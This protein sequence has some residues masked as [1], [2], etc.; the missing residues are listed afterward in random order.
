MKLMQT[1]NRINEC[2]RQKLK[3]T[4]NQLFLICIEWPSECFNVFDIFRFTIYETN[5]MESEM[6]QREPDLIESNCIPFCHGYK[7]RGVERIPTE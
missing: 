7:S 3:W 1:M 2:R 5:R 6:K 4:K